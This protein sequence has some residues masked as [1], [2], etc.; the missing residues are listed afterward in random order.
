[1]VKNFCDHCGREIDVSYYVSWNYL[2]F[3]ESDGKF[4]DICPKCHEEIKRFIEN[5]EKQYE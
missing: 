2:Y 4:Y 3:D 1:M 5:K